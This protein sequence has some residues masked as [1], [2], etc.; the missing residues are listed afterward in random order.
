VNGGDVPT[1]AIAILETQVDDLSPQV[2][3][4]LSQELF[5]MGAYEVFSQPVAM[6]KSR[7]GILLTIHCP[8]SLVANCR[9]RIFQETTTLGIRYRLEERFVLPRSIHW[10]ETPYG[11]VR[12]KV[13]RRP[14]LY[15]PTVQPEYE[16][17]VAI[18]RAHHLSLR[19]V[20]EQ[21]KAL[22]TTVIGL[23]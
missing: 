22:A 11:S 15:H 17:C 23:D 8:P 10:V 20:L 19:E 5:I 6:K 16:D 12:V 2:L 3:A 4:Y 7:I 13:C 9:D 14:P 21:I 18:A 1:E